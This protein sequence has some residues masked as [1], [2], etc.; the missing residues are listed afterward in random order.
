MA[1]PKG[2]TSRVKIGNKSSNKKNRGGGMNKQIE[3]FQSA[4][5]N[6]GKTKVPEK[7]TKNKMVA[8]KLDYSRRYHQ[9]DEDDDVDVDDMPMS[10]DDMKTY[11][12]NNAKNI[13]FLSQNLR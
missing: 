7:F 13:S 12:T 2:K 9:Q 11:L 10:D 5:L 8:N 3:K 4:K 6:A 1:K